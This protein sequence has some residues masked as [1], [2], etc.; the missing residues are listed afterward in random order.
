MAA[1]A[2]CAITA[3]HLKDRTDTQAPPP[4]R[5]AAARRARHD[6]AD[7]PGDQAAA[8]RPHHPAPAP[9]ARHPLGRVDPPPPGPLTMVPQARQARPLTRIRPGQTVK[10][11]HL[12]S[13][14][15][16]SH[17]YTT[18]ITKKF[19]YQRNALI[20]RALIVVAWPLPV[21]RAGGPAAPH[22][23]PRLL[24]HRQQGAQHGGADCHHRSLP[25]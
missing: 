17:E 18:K 4:A 12:T 15:A 11:G 24:A 20:Y 14:L 6:P 22:R 16:F 9:A 25:S 13:C 7:H 23:E 5:P 3:A 10:Y 21:A 19:C 1:L 8:R 2:I